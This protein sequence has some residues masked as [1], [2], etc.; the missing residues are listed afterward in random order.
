MHDR[1]TASNPAA[2]AQPA[3]LQPI[4]AALALDSVEALH[5]EVGPARP[6]IYCTILGLAGG[7]LLSLPLVQVDVTLAAPAQV[8]AATER[9]DIR[10]AVSGRIRRL[11]VADNTAVAAAE[12]LLELDARAVDARLAHNRARQQHA[13][14]VLHDLTLLSTAA[15]EV[16]VFHHLTT[17][18]AAVETPPPSDGTP[19]ARRLPPNPSRISNFRSQIPAALPPAPSP[20]AE[21]GAVAAEASESSAAGAHAS[22]RISDFLFEISARNETPAFARSSQDLQR[23]AIPAP[24]ASEVSLI[25]LRAPAAP[26]AGSRFAKHHSAFPAPSEADPDFP[27]FITAEIAAEHSD[28]VARR[29]G[30]RLAAARARADCERITLL[31]DQGLVSRRD[32]DEARFALARAEADVDILRQQSL[33]RWQVRRRDEELVLIALVSEE[34]H[35]GDERT[36]FTVEAPVAG[37]VLGLAGLA[38][39]AWVAA[40]QALGVVSP[41]DELRFEAAVP[42]QRIGFIRPGQGVRLAIDTYAATT[43]GTLG[44]RVL[45]VSADLQAAPNGSM[46]YRVLIAPEA[47]ALRRPDGTLAPLR[48]GMAAQARFV[49]A[50]RSLLQLLHEETSAWLDPR[51][52]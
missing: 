9:T 46:S 40:G 34:A 30:L 38:E 31:T 33:A 4:P 45:E 42:P 35:L 1:P 28:Y 12:P 29:A 36:S 52:T 23:P 10:A 17:S 32:C 24:G 15:A 22:S 51:Q 18:P 13:R 7:A 37:T 2:P 39:G 27:D 48:K 3:G 41:D 20:A 16:A 43:W 21:S 47:T 19:A 6:W 50:R 25:D 8:R 49:V 26:I 11:W 44:G 5:A 14:D